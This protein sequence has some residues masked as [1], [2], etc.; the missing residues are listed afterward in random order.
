M[1]PQNLHQS[2]KNC[3]I[4]QDMVIVMTHNSLHILLTT[5]LFSYIES[6]RAELY[7]MY[8]KL[9][10]SCCHKVIEGHRNMH[11]WRFLPFL[12]PNNSLRLPVAIANMVSLESHVLVLLKNAYII[13]ACRGRFWLYKA[14][15]WKMSFLGKVQIAIT[16][17]G[18]GIMKNFFCHYFNL[19]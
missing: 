2:T 6:I 19:L 1:A 12:R 11:F 10:A 3:A 8:E 14:Q 18:S 17:C 7:I 5:K 9:V 13:E 16:S 15:I 4:F